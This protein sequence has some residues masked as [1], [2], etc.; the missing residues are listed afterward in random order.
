V[1]KANVVKPDGTTIVVEGSAEEVAAV[2][3]KLSSPARTSSPTRSSQSTNSRLGLV[4]QLVNDL[5]GEGYFK[6]K[7]SLADVQRRLEELGHIFPNTT[8]SPCLTRMVKK[9]ALRR[10]KDSKVWVYVS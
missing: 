5:V 9:R 7:R 8:I 1:A 6:S 10:L 2:L 4:A 3:A